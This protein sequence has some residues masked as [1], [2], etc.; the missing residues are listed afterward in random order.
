MKKITILA[1]LVALAVTAA[2]MILIAQ[3]DLDTPQRGIRR[4][5]TPEI[6]TGRHLANWF[7]EYLELDLAEDQLTTIQNIVESELPAIEGLSESM[8]DAR[9]EFLGNVEPGVF[10]ADAVR[11]FTVTQAALYVELMVAT[12]KLKSEV[13]AVLNT[14]QRESLSD[15]LASFDPWPLGPMAG[16]GTAGS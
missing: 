10:D 2:P 3:D 4:V 9:R 6:Q 7:G 12:A 16:S 5:P 8:A 15:R 14:D 13:L 1:I 11:H